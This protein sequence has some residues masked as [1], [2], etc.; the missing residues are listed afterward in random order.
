[1]LRIVSAHDPWKSISNLDLLWWWKALRSELLLPSATT[2][3]NIYLMDYSLTVDAIMKQLPSRNEV[4][5]ALEGWTSTSKLAITL[6]IVYYMDQNSAVQAVQLAVDEVDDPYFTLFESW[7]WMIGQVSTNWSKF[8][9]TSEWRSW[10]FW[11]YWQPFT[12]N[13]NWSHFLTWFDDWG[14][15]I[16]L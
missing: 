15:A 11:A 1:M 8:S 3:S 9:S 16:N 5:S 6:V 4:S 7:F 14:T 10:S 2:L 13:Y 12:W